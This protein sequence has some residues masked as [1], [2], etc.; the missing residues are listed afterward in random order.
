MG[1]TSNASNVVTIRLQVSKVLKFPEKDDKD[2]L[3]S[4]Y[5]SLYGA[6]PLASKRPQVQEDEQEKLA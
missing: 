2:S 5:N 4:F 6:M 3:R 1:V